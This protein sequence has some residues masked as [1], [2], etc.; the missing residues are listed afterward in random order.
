MINTIITTSLLCLVDKILTINNIKGQ[1]YFN[2][3]IVNSLIVFSTY[4]DVLLPYTNFD[5][6]LDIGVNT[7]AVE[8]TFSIHLYHIIMYYN[9]FLFDDWL[10]HIVMIFFTLP[11]GL[12]FNCGPIMGHS[13]FFLTGLP[14]GINY[15]LLFLQRNNLIEKKTQKYYNYQLN[16][17]IRQ[18]GCIATS[19]LALL[20][21]N[22]YVN[23]NDYLSLFF[24]SYIGI[25]QYWNGVY[26]M[27]QVVR[28]Y[29]ILYR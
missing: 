27:E 5:N 23:K 16:I 3:F 10:H 19:I 15:L 12:Y 24:V 6:I 25:S 17:W 21:Y 29:N 7:T 2:H 1:Y 8:Y 26:F 22:K 14:G 28:N 11:M 18:P 4:N 13:L 9:K 20:Y